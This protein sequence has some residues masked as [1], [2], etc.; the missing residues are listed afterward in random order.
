MI[1]TTKIKKIAL[2]LG[3]LLSCLIFLF[4]VYLK[5]VEKYRFFHNLDHD[6][7][8]R[9]MLSIFFSS[10]DEYYVVFG[11]HPDKSEYLRFFNKVYLLESD[12]LEKGI[13]IDHEV[14]DGD[15][16][17]SIHSP[18]F[19]VRR[20]NS[21][22]SE[23]K[24][25]FLKFLLSG[26]IVIL[27]GKTEQSDF[28]ESRRPAINL[29]R[30]GKKIENGALGNRIFEALEKIQGDFSP[31]ENI[32]NSYRGYFGYS[33]AENSIFVICEENNRP[34]NFD[35]L[36]EAISNSFQKELANE[37]VDHIYFELRLVVM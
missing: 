28:C 15:F 27:Y 37:D 36:L 6:Y 26:E 23:K 21:F 14:I 4:L 31:Q 35:I 29:I 34:G 12:L 7:E 1:I 24:Y 10:L 8:I 19:K 2:S 16:A 3:L 11:K 13:V 20:I 9:K 25:N 33:K 5:P 18:R 22:I 17:L 32:Q 30:D